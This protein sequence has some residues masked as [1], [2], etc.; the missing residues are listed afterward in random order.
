MRTSEPGIANA[1]AELEPKVEITA[2]MVEA[3]MREYGA[4]WRGL[5][6]ADD[7]VAREMLRAAYSAMYE[8]RPLS[9]RGDFSGAQNE[10]E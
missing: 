4:R 7:D 9:V 8:L 3:G 5:R 6:D 2:E 1:A 10:R